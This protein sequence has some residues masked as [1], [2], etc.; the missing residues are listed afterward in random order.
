MGGS[1][2]VDLLFEHGGSGPPSCSTGNGGT[3]SVV[4]D[5]PHSDGCG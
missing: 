1:V 3:Y 5:Y 2:W 4:S